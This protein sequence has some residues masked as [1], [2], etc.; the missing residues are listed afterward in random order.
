VDWRKTRLMWGKPRAAAKLHVL[1]APA[2]DA[3]PPMDFAKTQVLPIEQVAQVLR[4]HHVEQKPA[5]FD[6]A[7]TQRISLSLLR[8]TRRPRL[9]ATWALLG[10]SGLIV[11][12]AHAALS[13]SS[14]RPRHPSTRQP[15]A[16]APVATPAPAVPSRP[17]PNPAPGAPA[18]SQRKLVDALASGDSAQAAELYAEQAAR[19]RNQ[20]IWAVAARV[21]AARAKPP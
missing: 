21:L 10:V 5:K 18:I 1:P 12:S 11:A 20:R 8:K 17:R 14:S 13:T 3:L 2:P 16:A 4:T 9:R 7:R 6:G 15:T 19:D